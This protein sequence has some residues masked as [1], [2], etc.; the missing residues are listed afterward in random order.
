MTEIIVTAIVSII[1]SPVM[2]KGFNQLVNTLSKKKTL[3]NNEFKDYLY[4]KVEEQSAH[5]EELN[6]VIV[7][8]RIEITALRA[9]IK[10]LEQQTNCKN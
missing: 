2:W 8:L 6:K 4:K 3:S 1:A 9:E 10:I 7:D 5:I